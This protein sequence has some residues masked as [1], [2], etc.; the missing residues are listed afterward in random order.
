MDGVFLTANPLHL[1]QQGV[2]ADV[3][4]ISGMSLGHAFSLSQSSDGTLGLQETAMTKELS[5]R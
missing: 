4:F 5:S 2:V 1:I 3:P